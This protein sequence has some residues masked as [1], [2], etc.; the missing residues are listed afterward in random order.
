MTLEKRMTSFLTMDELNQT[1]WAE[2]FISQIKILK[3]VNQIF[4]CVYH[5]VAD[6]ANCQNDHHLGATI[7]FDHVLPPSYTF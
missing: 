7:I 2:N 4:K 5:K 3:R 6:F 1:A